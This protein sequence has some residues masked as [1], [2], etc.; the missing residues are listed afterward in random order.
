MQYEVDLV[1]R[2]RRIDATIARA[3]A[4]LMSDTKWRKLFAALREQGVTMLRWKFV[5]DDRILEA[6]VP[7]PEATLESILGDP[8][9]SPGRRY[10]E[11][12]WVE[13][14]SDQST[15][16]PD[17]LNAVGKFPLVQKGDGLRIAAYRW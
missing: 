3:S 13:I 12:E 17:A 15:G 10:R 1:E 2:Q 7:S 16:I 5:R 14:P 9:P 8:S 6:A 11:I 4:S